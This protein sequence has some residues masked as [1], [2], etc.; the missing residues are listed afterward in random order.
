MAGPRLLLTKMDGTQNDLPPGFEVRGYPTIFFIPARKKHE[1]VLYEGDRSYKDMKVR[2]LLLLVHE[3]HFIVHV[4][5]YL[6]LLLL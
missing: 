2:E 5:F 6:N 1:S 4:C 3:K